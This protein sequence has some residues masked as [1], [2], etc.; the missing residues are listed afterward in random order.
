MP[1]NILGE[2]IDDPAR[3]ETETV[4]IEHIAKERPAERVQEVEHG[5]VEQVRSLLSQEAKPKPE[6]Q[7]RAGIEHWQKWSSEQAMNGDFVRIGEYKVLEKIG[8]GG[9]AEVLKVSAGKDSN[10]EEI[11]FAAKVIRLNGSQEKIRSVQERSIQAAKI[12]ARHSHPNILKINEV[13][14]ISDEK[15]DAGYSLVYI[16]PIQEKGSMNK[17]Q[18]YVAR[19]S[20]VEKLDFIED[21]L[22]PLLQALQQFNRYGLHMDIKPENILYND[23]EEPV[24]CDFGVALIHDQIQKYQESAEIHGTPLYMAPE[25]VVNDFPLTEKVDQYAIALTF[26]SVLTGAELYPED[27]FN[28]IINKKV[29]LAR[30]VLVNRAQQKKVEDRLM[31]A[32]VPNELVEVLKKMLQSNPDNRFDT[33]KILAKVDESLRAARAR[34]GEGTGKW[35]VVLDD[36]EFFRNQIASNETVALKDGEQSEE[37]V[38]FK[39]KG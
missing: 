38:L 36:P 32:G 33:T 9:E 4:V 7:W 27:T 5:V 8:S 22:T 37:T 19:L 21:N 26:F 12:A 28:K 31:D 18:N 13:A 10:G 25:Q 6:I 39:R 23:S 17:L 30:S 15:S 35:K 11:L 14:R 16:T 29:Q 24:I 1:Q 34:L 20:E 2:N 3:R